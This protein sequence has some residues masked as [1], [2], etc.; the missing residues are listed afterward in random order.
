M[1]K[2]SL[3]LAALQTSIRNPSKRYRGIH[4]FRTGIDLNQ[5]VHS[6]QRLF[7]SKGS[8]QDFHGAPFPRNSCQVFG[9]KT[10]KQPVSAIREIL[11]AISRCLQFS[12][13]L[14]NFIN[15]QDRYQVAILKN[16]CEL[17]T[18]YLNAIEIDF[19]KSIWLYQNLIASAYISHSETEP[20]DTSARVL[21]EVKCN[22]VLHALLYYS[23]KRIEGAT[24]KEK[25]RAEVVERIGPSGYKTYFLT[26][27]I[28]AT[29]SSESAVSNLLFFDAQASVIDHYT[30]LILALQAAV[31]AE[32]FENDTASLV[33]S[34]LKKLFNL[35]G[36]KRLIGVLAALGE[37]VDAESGSRHS[38]RCLAIEAYTVGNYGQCITLA[39]QV[40]FTDPLDIAIRVLCCKA[41][42]AIERYPEKTEGICGEIQDSLFNIFSANDQFFRSAYAL[43]QMSDRFFDHNWARYLRVAVCYELGSEESKRSQSWMRDIYVLDSHITPFMAIALGEE[44]SDKVVA[45]LEAKGNFL[46]TLN[47][48]RDVLVCREFDCATPRYAKYRARE[49]L[50][51]KQYQLAAESYMIAAQT[52]PQ[53]A[54]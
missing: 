4:Q 18:N 34:H 9:K 11:W 49:L 44:H 51:R 42:V 27:L 28:D 33:K 47:L 43:L 15:L 1:Q 54:V 52:E 31:S 22:S 24:L 30:S 13:E 50:V 2:K 36:D 12:S 7:P 20:A 39:T 38:D 21:E 5:F 3:T 23:R 8:L 25:L 53:A 26:K 32:M 29:D 17:A 41:T 14:R 16:D 45:Y 35:T 46:H 48:V 6:Y 40:L 37:L 19:G 10:P